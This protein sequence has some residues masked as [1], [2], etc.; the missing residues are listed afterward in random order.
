MD[1]VLRLGCWGGP[2][3]PGPPPPQ[4][5]GSPGEEWG[6]VNS[7]G[8]QWVAT[9]WTLTTA[10]TIFWGVPC[11]APPKGSQ[12]D[13]CPDL[14]GGVPAGPTPPPKE[15]TKTGVKIFWE[16]PCRAPPQRISPEDCPLGSRRSPK[17][18]ESCNQAKTVKQR[19]QFRRAAQVNQF[20]Q[21]P[22]SLRSSR[23][24][25]RT[26]VDPERSRRLVWPVLFEERN[27]P[28]S[29]GECLTPPTSAPEDE[30]LKR[31]H[32]QCRQWRRLQTPLPQ[33]TS[34]PL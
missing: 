5:S 20:T 13:W 26:F 9:P 29:T 21:G 24:S 12:Y 33:G 30:P 11:R 14:L 28:C 31:A 16:V 15:P 10:V 6:G 25:Q 3:S 7:V 18:S 2:P 22:L 8:V 27:E 4:D 32:I 19:A 1:A 17:R 34:T 23:T